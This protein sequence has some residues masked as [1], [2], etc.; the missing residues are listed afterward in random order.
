[1]GG[2]LLFFLGLS[3][4]VTHELDAIRRHEWRIFP[5]TAGMPERA[6]YSI[7]TAAHIPL[8]LLLFWGLSSSEAVRAPLMSGLSAFSI[9]HV[10]LHLLVLSHPLNQFSSPFSWLLI[11]GAGLCG[12]LDLLVRR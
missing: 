4:L 5:L 10:L 9:V 8:F 1:M 2:E 11:G 12:A 3:L 6:G 7:F